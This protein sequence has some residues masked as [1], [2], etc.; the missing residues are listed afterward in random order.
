MMRLLPRSTQTLPPPPRSTLILA[1]LMAANLSLLSACAGPSTLRQGETA[2]AAG[3]YSEGLKLLEQANNEAGASQETRAA[4]LR[5]RALVLDRLER[6]ARTAL[7][8]GRLEEAASLFARMKDLDADRAEAGA[9]QVKAQRELGQ[10]LEKAEA[11][12][13]SGELDKAQNLLRGILAQSPEHRQAQALSARLQEKAPARFSGIPELGPEYKKLVT[14]EFRDVGLKAVFDAIWHASGINFV[15]DKDIRSDLKATIM[16]KD[17]SVEEAVNAILTTQQL[18][19]RVLGPKM[20]FIYPRTPQKTGEYQDLMI[21]NFFLSHVGAKE[22]QNLLKAILKV[23]EIYADEKR[24]LIVVRDTPERIA[25]AEKLIQAQDQPEPEVMLALDVIEIS[26]S[27]LEDMGITWPQKVEL[28]VANPISLRSLRTLNSAG[29]NVGVGGLSTTA[30]ANGILAQLNLASNLGDSKT[31]ANP[32]IRVRNR[33]KAKI[34]IGDRLPVVTTTASSTSTFVGQTVNYLDVGLK[35]EVEPEVLLD[36]DVVIKLNLEVSSATQD[37]ANPTFYDVGTR[38]TSTVLTIRDGET[39]VLAGLIRNDE[40]DTN[41]GIPGLSELPLLGRLFSSNHN[42]KTKSEILLA[43]TPQVLRNLQRPSPALLEYL[44]GSE[45][46]HS[47]IT[48][49][50]PAPPPPRPPG[51]MP[52][53]VPAPAPR[54]ALPD[55]NATFSSSNASTFGAPGTTTTTTQGNTAA[56]TTA[57]TPPATATATTT[58]PTPTAAGTGVTVSITPAKVAAPVFEGPPG[59]GA[60]APAPAVP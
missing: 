14:L 37:K 43:I 8:E 16:V 59:V 22:I 50:Q 2:I 32:R 47:G 25:L 19:K 57:G 54:S 55:V 27:K 36:N 15:L 42:N 17:V 13:R 49:A 11:A 48:S 53:P 21:R 44:S 39:Q 45:N 51:A 23:K 38:N 33:E 52:R 30:G 18:G 40:S 12:L 4:L 6:S 5:Q 26:R 56:N 3:Q 1:A 24:N 28:G 31:L 41:S 10:A 34:H 46:G 60:P 9:R 58:T 35:L 29:I 20:L 7:E